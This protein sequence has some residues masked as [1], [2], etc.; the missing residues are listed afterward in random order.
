MRGLLHGIFGLIGIITFFFISR[1][2]GDGGEALPPAEIG[3]VASSTRFWVLF[4]LGAVVLAV[5]VTV[6]YVSCPAGTGMTQRLR[7]MSPPAWAFAILL[8]VTTFHWLFWAISQGAWNS[9][10]SSQTFWP[11]N[12]AIVLA[13]FF[14]SQQGRA[15]GYAGFALWTLLL[16]AIGV[17]T[18]GYFPWSTYWGSTTTTTTDDTTFTVV[19][20]LEPTEPVKVPLGSGLRWE[21]TKR[22][23]K[24]EVISDSGERVEFPTESYRKL[25]AGRWVRFRS[26]EAEPVTIEIRVVRLQ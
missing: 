6:N 16:V 7:G 18:H 1:F 13:A 20:G 2:F 17:G 11:M 15:A 5:W 21:S 24:F 23:A 26:L 3:V 22:G 14:A 25:S 4:V 19:A 12:V 8:G 10:L 9:W